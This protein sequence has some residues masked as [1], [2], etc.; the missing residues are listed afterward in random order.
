MVSG[1]SLKV[2]DIVLVEAGDT[3]PS[4]GEI[5]EKM[6]V[7]GSAVQPGMKLMRIEEHSTMW[8]DVDVYE[9]HLPFISIGQRVVCAGMVR[10]HLRQD[11]IE[12]IRVMDPGIEN[13]RGRPAN[14]ARVSLHV[15][16]GRASPQT[17]RRLHP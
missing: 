14:V 15:E 1:T 9:Q 12:Q 13:L 2:G 3:I 11:G 10:F 4:D 16:Q 8:L 17:V 7:Q 6:V 5:V